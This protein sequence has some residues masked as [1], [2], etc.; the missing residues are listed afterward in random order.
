MLKTLEIVYNRIE[1]L[2]GKSRILFKI[3]LVPNKKIK[4]LL[5]ILKKS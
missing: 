2:V 4:I 3:V 5:F 1:K